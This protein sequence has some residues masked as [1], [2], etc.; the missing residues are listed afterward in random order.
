MI[1]TQ[2]LNE[3]WWRMLW[4]IC[5]SICY[6]RFVKDL[7]KYLSLNL[8]RKIC[9]S[10]WC[11]MGWKFV[12][13]SSPGF[14]E[15][16]EVNVVK[17]MMW[18]ECEICSSYIFHNLSEYIEVFWLICYRSSF[19]MFITIIVEWN[20]VTI[21]VEWR[22]EWN[23][24]TII[25]EWN[26]ATIIVEWR[27]EWRV[28]TIIVEWRVANRICVCVIKCLS[29]NV[30]HLLSWR[31]M[32]KNYDALLKCLCWSCDEMWWVEVV[33]RCDEL[34]L[35]WSMWWVEVVMRCDEMWWRMYH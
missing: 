21:I 6:E 28:V 9:E 12:E 14:D 1:H 23:F 7:M 11:I 4:N 20:F 16:C 3:L 19:K 32:I 27:V 22:V 25:V 33:M 10:M 26:F 8:L 24:V 35:W 34:K 2:S 13:E 15:C 17:W 18:S 29:K 5:H 30:T 31:F